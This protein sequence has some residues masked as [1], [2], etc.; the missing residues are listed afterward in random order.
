[1]EFDQR[2]FLGIDSDR[3]WGDHDYFDS[4]GWGSTGNI[5][6]PTVCREEQC[7]LHFSFNG[8]GGAGGFHEGQNYLEM[9]ATNKII[10]VYPESTWWNSDGSVDQREGDFLTNQGLYPKAI[11]AM[12]CRLT[13]NDGSCPTGASALTSLAL[14]LVTSAWLLQ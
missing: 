8:A 3:A 6:I 4:S 9:A 13:T 10:M 12:V 11:H 1:M 2:E 5:Y 7:K 14:A